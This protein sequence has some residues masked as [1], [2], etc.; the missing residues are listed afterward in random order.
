MEIV[1]EKV[2]LRPY[3]LERCPEFYKGYGAD[4]ALTHDG[5]VYSQEKVD[6]YYRNKVMD[7]SRRSFAICY[8][9]SHWRDSDPKTRRRVIRNS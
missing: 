9:E 6:H 3:T 7:E 4:P 5:D 8:N 1:G 2:V